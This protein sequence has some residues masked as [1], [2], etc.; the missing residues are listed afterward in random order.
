VTQSVELTLDREAEQAVRDQWSRLAAAGLPTEQRVQPS[1]THRPHITLVALEQ[2]APEADEALPAALAGLDLQVRVGGLLL[3]GPRRGH[4]VLAR[5]V[6]TSQ[7]LLALQSA[8]ATLCGVDPDGHFGA[9]RWTPHV[10]LARRVPLD[11]LEDVVAA[12]GSPP[13]IAATVRRCR[14][15]DSER[16]ETWELTSR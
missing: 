1:P 14:R 6:V 4:L 5:Q 9:G 16:R 15:W 10:T 11:Q 13:E 2:L 7:P 8:V 3:F 12:L